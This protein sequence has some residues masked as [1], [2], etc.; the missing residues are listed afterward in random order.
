MIPEIYFRACDKI[1]RLQQK[2]DDKNQ[3]LLEAQDVIRQ[4]DEL[5]RHEQEFVAVWRAVSETLDAVSPGWRDDDSQSGLDSAVAAIR[6]LAASGGSDEKR[7][8]IYYQALTYDVCNTLDRELG[9]RVVC[10][11]ANHPSQG[12]QKALGELIDRCRSPQAGPMVFVD[13]QH[14]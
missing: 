12:V 13:I 2:L 3:L 9:H 10:G 7:N 4:A 1:K 5:L 8:R 6:K 14:P 11:T